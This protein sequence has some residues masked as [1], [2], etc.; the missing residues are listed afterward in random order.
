M[1][2]W[3]AWALLWSVVQ[4]NGTRWECFPVPLFKAAA[5]N[6]SVA[7]AAL[8]LV[9]SFVEGVRDIVI[10][11]GS[12]TSILSSATSSRVTSFQ[13]ATEPASISLWCL[14]PRTPQRRKWC[15][16]Y[17]LWWKNSFS[18]WDD[19]FWTILLNMISYTNVWTPNLC[20]IWL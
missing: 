2:V 5:L 16:Q 11:T 12:F 3:I 13:P 8:R 15:S 17:Q 9:Q 20:P 18:L 14:H 6:E 19:E 7:E 10:I 4:S 1:C